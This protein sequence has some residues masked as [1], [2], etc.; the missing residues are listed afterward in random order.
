MAPLL[1]SVSEEVTGHKVGRREGD[2]PSWKKEEEKDH[3]KR[4]VGWEKWLQLSR[5][6]IYCIL[7]SISMVKNNESRKISSKG[8]RK[9]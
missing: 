7:S 4:H 6:I 8:N 5:E 2:L 9:P 3:C 1:H